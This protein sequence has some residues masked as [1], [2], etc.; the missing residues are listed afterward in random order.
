MQPLK[1]ELGGG[2]TSRGDGWVNVDCL[3][4]A[5]IKCELDQFPWPFADNSVT[6]VYSS[7]CLEHLPDPKAAMDEICRI[8]I[9][10]CPVEIRVPGPGSD[11]AM[12][13]S[14]RHVFSPVQAINMDRHFTAEFWTGPKRLKL[15][16]FEYR[17]SFLLEEFRKEM[18]PVF[19]DLSDHQIMKWFPRTCHEVQF[20]YEVVINE[21]RA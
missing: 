13:Y 16:N 4:C 21:Y 15:L 6:A 17:E 10:G 14:H 8:G 18:P 5:D 2:T 12:V 19:T 1:V 11:M 9:V 20:F 3:P 7:H